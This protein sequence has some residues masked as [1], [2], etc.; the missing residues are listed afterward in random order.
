MNLSMMMMTIINIM[1]SSMFFLTIIMMMKS[2]FDDHH[3]V[4]EVADKHLHEPALGV[5]PDQAGQVEA[6]RL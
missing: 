1:G 6:G 3:G 5:L 2:Y 4:G